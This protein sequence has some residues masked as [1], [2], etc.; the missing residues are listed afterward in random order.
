MSL[1]KEML[2][3]WMM[4][5][6]GELASKQPFGPNGRVRL[7]FAIDPGF[8]TQDELKQVIGEAR[9]KGAHLI[10]SHGTKV[11]MLGETFENYCSVLRVN[12]D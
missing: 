12:S 7:G 11:A 1:H 10:T 8:C 3:E 5:T 2:P 9:A 6:F 4:S